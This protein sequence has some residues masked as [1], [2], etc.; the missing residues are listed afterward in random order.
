ML[1]V[2]ILSLRVFASGSPPYPE[3]DPQS[4]LPKLQRSYRMKRP[5]DCGGPL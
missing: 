5:Y 2:G 3:L 1:P 4:V